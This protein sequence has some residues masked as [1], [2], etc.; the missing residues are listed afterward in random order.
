M[1][2][3]DSQYTITVDIT[4]NTPTEVNE[5]D[6]VSP[7]DMCILTKWPTAMCDWNGSDPIL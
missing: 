7:I 1:G 2:N 3:Q 4:S 6:L 5:E